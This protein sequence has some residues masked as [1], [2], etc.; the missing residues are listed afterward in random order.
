MD[1][2]QNGKGESQYLAYL[3]IVEHVLERLVFLDQVVLRLRIKFN[4]HNIPK[5]SIAVI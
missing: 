3:Q 1:Q 2:W 5:I 4:L